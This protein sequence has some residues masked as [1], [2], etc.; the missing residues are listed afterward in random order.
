MLQYARSLLGSWWSGKRSHDDEEGD[1]APDQ[2]RIRSDNSEGETLHRI[3]ISNF[4]KNDWK[5]VKKYLLDLG[6]KPMSKSPKWDYGIINAAVSVVYFLFFSS[7]K[8]PVLYMRFKQLK[9]IHF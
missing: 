6:C 3:K 5:K 7:H 4:N 1:D 2:K 9:P 8:K